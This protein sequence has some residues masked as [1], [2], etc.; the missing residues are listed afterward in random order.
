MDEFA[1][2]NGNFCG[3]PHPNLLAYSVDDAAYLIGVSRR[4]LYR[5]VNEQKIR[6]KKIG[7]RRVIAHAELVRFLQDDSES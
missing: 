4:T 6:S 1:H 5:L 3:S 2:T 7:S